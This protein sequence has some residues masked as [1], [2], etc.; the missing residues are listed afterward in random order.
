M[1]LKDSIGPWVDGNGLVS[2]VPSQGVMRSSDNGVM[3]TSEYFIYLQKN[4]ELNKFDSWIYDNL[5]RSCMLTPGL[6]A[7][8][9]GDM[10]QS[11]P[12][13]MIAVAAACS[14]LCIPD[15]ARE[16]LK[17][18][19][20]H[21]GSFNN[22]NPTVWTKESFLWRQPQ[23]LAALL[24][25]ARMGQNNPLVWVLNL[26]AALVI[27]V[28]GKG[29]DPQNTDARRLSWLLIQAMTPVSGVC[30]LAAKLWKRRAEKDY[31]PDFMK[32]ICAIYYQPRGE[33]PFAEYAIY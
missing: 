25:A 17:Y 16:I 26:Y 8:A 23:L 2:C 29:V 3:F 9:P 1:S 6:L 7:R 28:A 4:Y 11:P 12:D 5:M 30:R 20:T 18:G 22:A 27:A 10:G 33:H 19:F 32:A 21:K 31:G 24:A 15:L 14:Q 13:D